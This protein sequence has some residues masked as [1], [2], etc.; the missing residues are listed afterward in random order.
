MKGKREALSLRLIS[1]FISQRKVPVSPAQRGRSI[2][3]LMTPR[4]EDSYPHAPVG[5]SEVCFSPQELGHVIN[6]LFSEAL[7]EGDW[8]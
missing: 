6:T 7:A 4:I 5:W 3:L 1:D 8:I 2:I